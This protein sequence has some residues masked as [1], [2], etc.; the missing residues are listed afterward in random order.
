MARKVAQATM[1]N[2]KNESFNPDFVLNERVGR[3]PM[4]I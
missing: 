1:T 3:S 4:T 2:I